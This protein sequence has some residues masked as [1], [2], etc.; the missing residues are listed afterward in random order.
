[1]ERTFDKGERGVSEDGG[2]GDEECDDDD[3]ERQIFEHLDGVEGFRAIEIY[4]QLNKVIVGIYR[5][6]GNVNNI[7]NRRPEIVVRCYIPSYVCL[8]DPLAGN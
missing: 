7:S 1:M 2:G 3:L 6:K 8:F 5:T 4:G